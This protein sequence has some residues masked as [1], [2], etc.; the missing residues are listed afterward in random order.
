METNIV[1]T[2]GNAWTPAR[3]W[4]YKIIKPEEYEK[5]KK[6]GWVKSIRKPSQIRTR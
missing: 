6:D 5:Y 3:F 1:I 4:E 2:R